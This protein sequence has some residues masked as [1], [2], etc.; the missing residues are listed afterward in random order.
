[1]AL[2]ECSAL[3]G[4]GK[5]RTVGEEGSGSNR[6]KSDQKLASWQLLG[7]GQMFLIE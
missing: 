3:D 6:N 1:M 2:D 5:L 7:A 4:R